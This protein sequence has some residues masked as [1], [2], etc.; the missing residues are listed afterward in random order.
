M[1]KIVCSNGPL[2]FEHLITLEQTEL[3]G[4]KMTENACKFQIFHFFLKI[5]CFF[6]VNWA[7]KKI[8][9]FFNKTCVFPWKLTF[10]PQIGLKKK[11]LQFFNKTCVFTW[12]LTIFTQI[13]PKKKKKFFNFSVKLLFLHENPWFLANFSTF[14]RRRPI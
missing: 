2:K 11:F 7:K 5:P 9:Q 13:G 3:Q 4:W 1:T 10:L 12:K 8:L 14:L 6:A